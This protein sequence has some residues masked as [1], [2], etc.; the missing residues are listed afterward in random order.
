M[1]AASRVKA[2]R[3]SGPAGWGLLVAARQVV[4]EE[5]EVLVPGWVERQMVAINWGLVAAAGQG[6]VGRE[7]AVGWGPVAAVVQ[8]WELVGWAAVGRGLVEVA[9]APSAQGPWLRVVQ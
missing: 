4:A 9:A 5:G 6:W 3:G 2:E 7:V 8:G 1:E